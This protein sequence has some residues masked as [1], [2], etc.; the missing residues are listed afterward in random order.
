VTVAGIGAFLLLPALAQS[1][2]QP[3]EWLYP[4]VVR[5]DPKEVA[6]RH[7]PGST[8]TYDDLQLRDLFSTID[9]RPEQHPPMPPV[10]AQGRKPDVQACGY[11]HLA[12]GQGRPESAPVAGLPVA[13][14]ISQLQ[15]FAS[16]KRHSS[17]SGSAPRPDGSLAGGRFAM[18][19][20]ASKMTPDEMKA[21][22]DYF[23]ALKYNSWIKVTEAETAPALTYVTGYPVARS[24]QP[25][26]PLNGRIV[27][28]ADDGERGLLRDPDIGFT[29]LVPKGSITRGTALI[30]SSGCA[31]CH[32]AGLKGGMA[33]PIAGRSPTYIARSLYD[34][35]HGARDD[36]PAQP[37]KEP[38]AKLSLDDMVAVAAYVGSLQP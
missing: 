8:A 6:P 37:M 32:G 1:Q 15:A 33:P 13:Y 21:A 27:E 25:A 3:P 35:A 30:K 5:V 19:A 29:A 18:N 22:A 16:G 14:F 36:A 23:G 10:V 11:C 24:D 20:M 26:E 38:A 9:W 34:F 7:V 28:I 4:K 31:G 12:T 2:E 17:S